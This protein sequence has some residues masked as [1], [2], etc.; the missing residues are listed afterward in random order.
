MSANILESKSRI[1]PALSMA[2]ALSMVGS[3]AEAKP[4]ESNTEEDMFSVGGCACG[5]GVG[6]A[7]CPTPTCRS[8]GCYEKIASLI[9]GCELTPVAATSIGVAGQAATIVRPAPDNKDYFLPVKVRIIA[10]DAVD[11]TIERP[12]W[13]TA[14]LI[15][16]IPQ[17]CMNNP[18]PTTSPV[19]ARSMVPGT[20]FR[21]LT[22][23]QGV[24]VN[25]GPFSITSLT[26]RLEVHVYNP[27]LAAAT[28]D[29]TV[30]VWGYCLDDLP[31]PLKCGV[32]PSPEAAQR[33]LASLIKDAA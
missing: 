31:K 17:W 23:G 28:A 5:S 18:A 21:N 15:G 19:A 14:A 6:A 25:W 9:K 20:S 29:I 2:M 33:A 24:P 3:E 1:V 22:D 10:R 30:E 32:Y 26:K 11:P 4:V 16:S 27:A 8:T 12:V 13:V 7:V